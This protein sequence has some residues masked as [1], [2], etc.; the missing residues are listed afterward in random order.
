MVTGV[1]VEQLPSALYRVDVDGRHQVTAHL[2]RGDGR[3]FIRVLVGDRVAVELTRQDRTRGRI[4]K[5]V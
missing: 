5:K 2:G 4:V 3:N 1:V